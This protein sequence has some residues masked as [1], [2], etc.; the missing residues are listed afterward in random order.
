MVKG[1]WPLLLE[2]G[3]KILIN[4]CDNGHVM[5]HTPRKQFYNRLKKDSLTQKKKK[6]ERDLAARHSFRVE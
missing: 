3:L 5:E 2:L 6:K 4:W 1:I